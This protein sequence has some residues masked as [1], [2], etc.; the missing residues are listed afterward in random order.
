MATSTRILEIRVNQTG[1]GATGIRGITQSLGGLGTLAAGAATAGI[2]VAGAAIIGLGAAA[3]K[4]TGQAMEAQDIQAQLN[5]VIESTGG[6]AGVTADMVNELAGKYQKLTR[7][8]DDAVVSADNILLTFTQIGKDVFP[9][10][11]GAVLDMATSLKLDLSSASQIVGKALN[12]PIQGVGALR[13]VGVQLTDEQEALVKSFMAVG[14]VAGAQ[15]VILGELQVEFGGSAIAAGRTFG[16]QL[17]RL[18]NKLN[19]AGENIMAKFLPV[20]GELAE[21]FIGGLNSPEFQAVLGALSSFIGDVVV[22]AVSTLVHWIKDEVVPRFREFFRELNERVGPIIQRI[23]D[24]INRIA[25]RF[26][27]AGGKVSLLDALFKGLD[28]TL[29]VAVPIIEGVLRII[30][31]LARGIEWV[32]RVIR[33]VVDRFDDMREAARRAA[34]AIP[35]WLRPGS[36]TP[37]EV[38]L[39][40]IADAMGGVNERLGAAGGGM[41]AMVRPPLAVGSGG[42]SGGGVVINFTYQTTFSPID[43]YRFE[44]E[45]KP[46]ITR[47]INEAKRG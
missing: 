38:G 42:A 47:L 4:F 46:M 16:G 15:K 19:D 30:E 45:V 9:E 24:H 14:D 17:D 26:G 20:L 31:G 8:E 43:S 28:V 1:E 6:K 23:T 41:S 11:T 12:D 29:R 2:A 32:S 13:R 5:N 40:G 37:F 33:T 18:R 39:R 44:Q 27:V 10:A 22:P 7:F 34:E 3:V 35:D 21:M 25:E 36:P